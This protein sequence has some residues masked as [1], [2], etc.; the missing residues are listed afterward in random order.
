MLVLT[1]KEGEKIYVGENVAITIV[2]IAGGTVRIGIE[3][4]PDTPI[5]RGEL[6]GT[7]VKDQTAPEPTVPPSA[8]SSNA[9]N[10]AK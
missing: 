5:M 8:T 6:K 4:L 2:R 1:R 3:A 9:S 7:L 10:I